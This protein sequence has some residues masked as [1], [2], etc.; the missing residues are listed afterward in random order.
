MSTKQSVFKWIAANCKQ[1]P[2][3]NI[4]MKKD[5]YLCRGLFFFLVFPGEFLYIATKYINTIS[6]VFLLIYFFSNIVAICNI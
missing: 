2:K 3:M 4:K 5:M 6:Y 1:V